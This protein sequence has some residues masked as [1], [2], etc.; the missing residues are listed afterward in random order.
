MVMATP[1]Q[2]RARRRDIIRATLSIA[3]RGGYQSVQMRTVAVRA[4]V[5]MGTLYR[6]FPSKTILLLSSLESELDRVERKVRPLTS[7]SADRYTCLWQVATHLNSAMAR[8]PRLT[9]AMARGF[10]DAY[11]DEHP[12]AHVVRRRL[13]T[14]FARLLC[15]GEPNPRQLQMARIVVDA[16]SSNALSWLN[17]RAT[18]EEINQ[19]L[20]HLLA[21]LARRDGVCAPPQN[22]PHT[23]H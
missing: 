23:L 12:D 6:Y 8:S 10:I 13:D 15:S 5:S 22:E 14:L 2:Q 21:L 4:G 18:T 3:R 17:H 9:E 20:W 11:T 7:G 19:R 16:W 1:A